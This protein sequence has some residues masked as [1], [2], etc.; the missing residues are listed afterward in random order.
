MATNASTGVF[1]AN[2]GLPGAAVTGSSIIKAWS[3][4]CSTNDAL[5]LFPG[6]VMIPGHGAAHPMGFGG[7]P[8][9]PA[10]AVGYGAGGGGRYGT[11]IAAQLG[12]AGAPPV[13]IVYEYA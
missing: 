10:S 4:G 7:G 13:I 2:A 8:G 5:I 9:A 12:G 1:M 3:G 6:P 11:N